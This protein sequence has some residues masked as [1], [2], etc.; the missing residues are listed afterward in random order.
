VNQAGLGAES[1]GHPP[2]QVGSVRL[3]LQ[4]A[5]AAQELDDPYIRKIHSWQGV[6]DRKYGGA[7]AYGHDFAAL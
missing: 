2:G 5:Q 6:D 3:G 7:P 1:L 4:L